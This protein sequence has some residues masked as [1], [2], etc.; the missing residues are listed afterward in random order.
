MKK[1]ILHNI[2]LTCIFQH[3]ETYENEKPVFTGM[4]SETKAG[5]ILFQETL[6]KKKDI[7]NA[8]L[9]E[10]QLLNIVRRKDGR[11]YPLLKAFRMEDVQNKSDFAFR[12]YSEIIDALGL[13][14]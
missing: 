7:R 11:Y 13:I 2:N 1:L 9:Y 5:D 10:G 6:P 14:E 8:R 3:N 12:I 4:L